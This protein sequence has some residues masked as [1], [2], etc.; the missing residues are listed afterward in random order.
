MGKSV[1]KLFCLFLRCFRKEG[2]LWVD[3]I[4]WSSCVCFEIIIPTI[5]L[6]DVIK[7]KAN[8]VRRGGR[9]PQEALRRRGNAKLESHREKDVSWLQNSSQKRQTM[10]RTVWPF[11]L[12]YENHISSETSKAEWTIEEEL[13]LIQYHNEIGNKWSLIA[14]KIPGKYPSIQAGQITVWRTT[15]TLSSGKFCAN[16]IQSSITTSEGN[17]GK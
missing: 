13:M 8:L 11:E 16:W 2:S 5:F 14:Q 12:S 6:L 4:L 10:S 9:H 7:P 15:F 1:Q 17:S 3:I